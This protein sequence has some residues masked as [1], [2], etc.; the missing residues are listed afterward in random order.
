MLMV[1]V[2][3]YEML[4]M[5]EMLEMPPATTTLF[6]FFVRKKC[7]NFGY[8]YILRYLQYDLSHRLYK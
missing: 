6:L 3:L 5:L 8:T 1:D 4:E 7:I 2:D